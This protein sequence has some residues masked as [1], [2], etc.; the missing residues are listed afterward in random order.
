[1]DIH[2]DTTE[3]YKSECVIG[4]IIKELN[5]DR[6][7]IFITSKI[8]LLNT[9]HRIGKKETLKTVSNSLKYLDTDYIDLFLIHSPHSFSKDGKDIIEIYETL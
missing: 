3:M 8:W 1:M 7:K 9:K 6:S 5:I 4:R 2:L